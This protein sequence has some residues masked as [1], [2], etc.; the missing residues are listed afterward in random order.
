MTSFVLVPQT[1]L[2]VLG[3]S[4]IVAGFAAMCSVRKT[5]Q[6]QGR[7]IAKLEKLMVKIGIFSVLYLIPTIC[8]IGCN[9]YHV[10]VLWHWKDMSSICK[11]GPHSVP[12]SICPLKASLPRVEVYMLKIF[13]SLIIG[14]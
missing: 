14:E 7:N 9:G 2:L 12:D 8:L 1:V 6:T 13:M 4:F 11:L 10:I 3:V 5:L